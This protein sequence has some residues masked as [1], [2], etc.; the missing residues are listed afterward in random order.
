MTQYEMHV[1]FKASESLCR[2]VRAAILGEDAG[3]ANSA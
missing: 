2:D 3:D 1:R